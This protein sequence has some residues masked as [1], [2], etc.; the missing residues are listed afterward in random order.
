MFTG[1]KDKKISFR[2]STNQYFSLYRIYEKYQQGCPNL[3]FS[4][5]IRNII[6]SITE[7]VENNMKNN[8]VEKDS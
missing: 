6:L 8:E 3:T 5:F 7:H 1:D 2:L 4:D